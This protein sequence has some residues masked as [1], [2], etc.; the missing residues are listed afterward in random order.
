MKPKWK[1][2][3]DQCTYL[4]SMHMHNHTSDWYVCSRTVLARRGDDGPDYWSMPTDM[5]TDDRYL[6]SSMDGVLGYYNMVV[7]ARFMLGKL[8]ERQEKFDLLFD[9][10]L[11][12]ALVEI[13]KLDTPKE[14][15]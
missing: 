8:K 1:H 11:L 13:R 9:A 5:V 6:T 12:K 15:T 3:C 2:D 4:G 14:T 10:D 7:M